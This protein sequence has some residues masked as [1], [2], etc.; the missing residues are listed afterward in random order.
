MPK[1]TQIYCTQIYLAEHDALAIDWISLGRQDRLC[2]DLVIVNL[3]SW[4]L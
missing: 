2:F 4:Y 1:C 3:K